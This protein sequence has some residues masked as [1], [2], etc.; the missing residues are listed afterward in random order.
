MKSDNKNTFSRRKFTRV[1]G[2]TS[3]GM[4]ISPA[5]FSKNIASPGIANSQVAVATVTNYDET[6]L[7]EAVTRSFALLGGLGDI[8]KPGDSVGIKIN[9]TGGATEARKYEL[10]SGRPAG[11]NYWTNPVLLKIVGQAIKEAGA[12]KLY[13]LEALTDSE[14]LTDF[15][16]KEVIDSLEATF[17]NLN[18]KA[19]YEDYINKSTGDNYLVYPDLT[20]NGIFNELDCLISMPK[21][22]LHATAGVTHGMKNLI[23]I[24]PLSCGIY[25]NQGASYRA[26]IHQLKVHDGIPANNLC[27]VILDL[28]AS[29][30]VH[31]VV[32][33][34]VKTVL[35]SEGPWT[36]SGVEP[37]DFNKIIIG[38]DPVAVD[39][40]S[41]SIM[42]F[43]PMADDNQS[44]FTNSL[45]YLRLA[46][47]RGF[48]EYDPDKI[49]VLD[50]ATGI[51]ETPKKV[52]SI[53]NYPNPF[54]P[55]T[56][57]QFSIHEPVHV[58]LKI[59][60]AQGQEIALL[61]DSEVQAG[62]HRLTWNAKDF[63][64]GIYYYKIKA[65]E[66]SETKQMLLMKK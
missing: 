50:T 29:N 44:P 57:I 20:L 19:P 33:D 22:K 49:E 46:S 32:N 47:Q 42:G 34:A 61:A 43:N 39:S 51:N 24:L 54:Y 31:L 64:N 48:G 2:A 1:V 37:A 18:E 53:F 58:N 55:D 8:I 45:N 11:E 52:Q 23:G 60:N 27:R 12:G 35:G 4:F 17:I 3:V 65:G 62:T 40:V 30:P 5:L 63:G 16:Y 59:Y 26:G 41:T 28:N 56:T 25:N 6:I 66:F 21:A 14:S 10:T 38:K 36:G 9:L 7:K 13:I 15:G